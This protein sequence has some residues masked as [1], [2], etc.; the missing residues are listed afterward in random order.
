MASLR[1]GAPRRRACQ[2]SLPTKRDPGPADFAQLPGSQSISPFLDPKPCV[3]AEEN[4]WT[5]KMKEFTARSKAKTV[6]LA[7]FKCLVCPLDAQ[8]EKPPPS[9]DVCVW[10][11]NKLEEAPRPL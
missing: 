7:D 2:P 11:G 9:P 8:L 3:N 1:G 6:Q 4:N 10:Q 5:V